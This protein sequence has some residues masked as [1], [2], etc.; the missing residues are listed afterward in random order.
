MTVWLCDVTA[1]HAG[2]TYRDHFAPTNVP[3]LK[4][5]AARG[6]QFDTHYSNAPVCCP[7]RASIWSG[8]QPHKINHTQT[9]NPA[10]AVAG[11]WNNYEGNPRGYNDLIGDVMERRG[12]AVK[13]SG[14]TDWTQGGHSLNVRLNSWTMY[15][16]FPY[17]VNK[18]GGWYDET[19]CPSNGS[20]APNQ[21]FKRHDVSLPFFLKKLGF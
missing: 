4:G 5:L 16:A 14:K 2:R 13:I 6:V 17:N 20:V 9:D 11:A 10:L 12:Y 19:D 15:T 21:I 8:R 3:N 18:S 7:S 1:V